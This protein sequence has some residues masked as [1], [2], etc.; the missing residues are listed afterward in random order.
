MVHIK[1]QTYV[2]SLL[3]HFQSDLIPPL[4]YRT[5]PPFGTDLP[6]LV[7]FCFYVTQVVQNHLLFQAQMLEPHKITSNTK[8][9]R[10][11]LRKCTD[12]EGN[13]I[14]TYKHGEG[15]VNSMYQAVFGTEAPPIGTLLK[16]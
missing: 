3:V 8:Y 7:Y 12:G 14:E 6:P 5:S 11:N 13:V 16:G 9:A 15:K 10:Q 2:H 4:R 1:H